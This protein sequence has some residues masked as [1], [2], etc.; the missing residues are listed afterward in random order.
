MR[1]VGLAVRILIALILTAALLRI[2]RT[3]SRG[4]PEF[5]THTENGFTFEMTTVPKAPENGKARIDVTIKGPMTDSLQPMLYPYA[6]DSADETVSGMEAIPLWLSDSTKGSYYAEI[7][8]G[9][10]GSAF[11]YSIQIFDENDRPVASFKQADGS[12][13]VTKS[14][15]E[16]PKPVL[17]GH[18]GF[19]FA[20]VFCVAMATT[21]ALS[22]LFGKGRIRPV[23]LFMFL[24]AAFTLIGG[25]PYGFAMNWYA[26]HTIWEGIPFGTDATDNKTQLLLVYLI[27][28]AI[29][30]LGTLTKGKFGRDVFGA[31]GLAIL[32]VVSFVL[33]LGIYL[34]PHS[35]QFSAATTYGVCCSFMAVCVIV[36]LVG[37]F[38]SRRVGS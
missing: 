8:A 30:G 20:T 29:S 9:V 18:I 12:P 16:V 2:A 24:A 27:L 15:G 37:F 23:V 35:I 4:H 26:F 22:A 19:M 17:I 31:T 7:A 3:T 21:F 33:M 36:Y 10:R 11:K 13:F 28:A 5:I 1:I 34:I 38:A 25:F 32:A 14:I 6:E